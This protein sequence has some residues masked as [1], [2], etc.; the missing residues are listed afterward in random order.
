MPAVAPVHGWIGATL[1]PKVAVMIALPE[2]DPATIAAASPVD[3][4]RR[5][6]GA[7]LCPTGSVVAAPATLKE[8]DVA[9]VNPLAVALS[10]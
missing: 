5:T 2:P 4:A 9:E 6:D 8:F 10:V 3:R 7:G 1:P